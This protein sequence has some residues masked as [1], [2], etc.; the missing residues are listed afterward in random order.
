M[1]QYRLSAIRLVGFHNYGDVLIPV[2]GDLFVVGANESGKTTILDAVHL[3]L[4][5][6]QDLEWNAAASPTGRRKSGRT[7]QGIILRAN[8]AGQATRLGGSISY[9]VVQLDSVDSSAQPTSLIFGASVTDMHTQIQK[10]AAV[11]P[12]RAEDLPLTE[13]LDDGARRILDRDEFEA[14]LGH[15]LHKGPRGLGDYR[16]SLASKLF[17]NREHF[18]EV[19]RL[20]RTGKSY[21]EIATTARDVGDVFRQVLP[22][23][24]PE[25][26][27]KIAKGF[28]DIAGIESELQELSRD[29]EALLNLRT[30]LDELREAREAFRRYCYVRES[31]SVRDRN[32][33]FHALHNRRDSALVRAEHLQKQIVRHLERL[34]RIDEQ[35][36]IHRESDA[37]KLLASLEAKELELKRIESR[38]INLGNKLQS[39]KSRLE[40]ANKSCKEKRLTAEQELANVRG[41]LD[42]MCDAAGEE[43]ADVLVDL[44]SLLS[45]LPTNVDESPDEDNIRAAAVTVQ[46]GIDHEI[47]RVNER[48]EDTM[49]QNREFEHVM[50]ELDKQLRRIDEFGDLVPLLPGLDEVLLNLKRNSSDTR[51][52]SSIWNGDRK[53][54]RRNN[55]Q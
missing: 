19:T 44:R 43:A 34:S 23:P 47:S 17:N 54:P 10:W 18:D 38:L 22:P 46:Q 49:R 55:R 52:C 13:S 28:R 29:V 11:A 27:R 45:R 25:P 35:L 51:F 39:E 12:V 15:R 5:G 32:A 53:Q 33:H 3:V 37:Y 40:Q 8:M 50:C 42:R 30:L 20:W 4:S 24:D 1:K 41:Q 36:A 7:L 21:H 14:R 16:V 48:L 2:R 31:W 26:F 6:E 9:A